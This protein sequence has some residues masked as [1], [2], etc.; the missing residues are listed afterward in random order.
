MVLRIE[1]SDAVGGFRR[2]GVHRKQSVA[3]PE[4]SVR[5]RP[6]PQTS[7]LAGGHMMLVIRASPAVLCG[8]RRNGHAS[9]AVSPS[10]VRHAPRIRA[11]DVHD[12]IIQ[13]FR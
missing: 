12:T 10:Q 7:A 9:N 13:A 5:V 8:A 6:G 11:A 2:R 1:L 3:S 4:E